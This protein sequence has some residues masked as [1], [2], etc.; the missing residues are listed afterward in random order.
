VTFIDKILILFAVTRKIIMT[1]YFND[2][3]L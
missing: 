3:V 1:S 2:G